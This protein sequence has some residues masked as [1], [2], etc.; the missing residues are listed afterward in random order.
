MLFQGQVSNSVSAAR[1]TGNPNALQL[2]LG[3]MAVSQVMP[4]YTALAQS[5]LLY[6]ARSALQATTVVGTA[7]VG[8]QIWNRTT[9]KNLVLLKTGGNIVATSASQTGVALAFGTQGTAAPTAQTAASSTINNLIGGAAPAA[10]ALAAGTFAA[11]PV[12]QLD[13]LHN[14]AAIASTGEDIGYVVDLEGSYVIPPGGFV[15]VCS[16]GATAAASSNNHWL[17]WAELPV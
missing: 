14:T 7:M 5:G 13:L 16:L 9:T 15:A 17:Q 12:A 10:L 8:L 11:A 2:W 1:Q 3:E 4:R 6:T